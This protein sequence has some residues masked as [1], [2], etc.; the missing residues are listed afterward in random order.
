MSLLTSVEF[1]ND[2]SESK[3]NANFSKGVRTNN[4]L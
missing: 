3:Y 1:E 2:K 4:A